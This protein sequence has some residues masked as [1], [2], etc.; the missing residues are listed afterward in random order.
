M[1]RTTKWMPALVVWT[2]A[3]RPTLAADRPLV[4]EYLHAGRLAEGEQALSEVLTKRP[5]DGQARFGLGAL[6]F[7][8]AIERLGQSLYRYGLRS[9]RGQNLGIPFLRLPIPVNPE[10][11]E[12]TYPAA[13]QILED[14]LGDLGM[15]E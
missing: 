4:E 6:Q 12:F 2:L 8:R 7:I 9:D 15:S 11:E 10:A 1:R 5:D 3:W 14:L 13:R